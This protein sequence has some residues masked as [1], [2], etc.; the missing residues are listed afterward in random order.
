MKV[1]KG[2][3]KTVSEQSVPAKATSYFL[4]FIVLILAT[5][6]ADLLLHWLNLVFIGRYLGVAGT[7]LIL[8]SLW[9]SLRKYKIITSGSPKKL[10]AFHEYGSWLGSFLI[11]VHAGIHFNALLPWLAV[12]AMLVNVASGLTGKYLHKKGLLILSDKKKEL[13]E[14]GFNNDE[15]EKL[16]YMD[17][18]TLDIIKKWRVVHMPITIAFTLFTLAHILFVL[19]YMGRF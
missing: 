6:V 13:A 11:L 8:A 17:V 12:A 14:R 3:K 16:I 2:N 9:Y 7:L 10:L 15:I 4:Q 1:F 5:I 18:L 19:K